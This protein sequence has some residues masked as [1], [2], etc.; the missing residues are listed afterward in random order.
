M[1]FSLSRLLLPALLLTAPAVA[2][3]QSPFVTDQAPS[4][5]VA[6]EP[7]ATTPMTTAQ[8]PAAPQASAVAGPVAE[9]QSVALKVRNVPAPAPKAPRGDNSNNRALMIVGGVG[10][11]VGAVIGGDEG[12]IVMLG[13]A[14]VGLLGL[15][16]FLN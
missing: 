10:M 8:A 3:A 16:R 12:T 6:V 7:K 15:Y 13:S 5:I 4:A 1:V 14:G 9:A 2:A 11:I